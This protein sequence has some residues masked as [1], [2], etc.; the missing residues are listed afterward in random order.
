MY[1]MYEMI[2]YSAAVMYTVQTPIAQSA[3]CFVLK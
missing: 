1:A 2:G 3:S